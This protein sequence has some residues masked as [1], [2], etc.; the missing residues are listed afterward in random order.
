M[1]VPRKKIKQGRVYRDSAHRR[2]ILYNW[3]WLGLP[4]FG[5][6]TGEDVVCEVI[7]LPDGT[8]Q[9]VIELPSFLPE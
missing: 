9:D 8:W 3:G 4:F 7:R 5:G 6:T 1:Y 2:G